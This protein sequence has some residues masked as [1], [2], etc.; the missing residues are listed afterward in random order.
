MSFVTHNHYY[1]G[2]D[3]DA[4]EKKL[5]KAL[6]LLKAMAKKTDEI[7]TLLEEQNGIISNISGDLDRIADRLENDPTDEDIAAIAAEIRTNN[8]QLRTISNRNLV[9]ET[10][11]P[12][13]EEPAPE[14]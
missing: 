5:D 7:K 1:L 11:T 10:E 9:A 12:P 14:A 13:T 3:P 6:K 4:L 8:D 2:P